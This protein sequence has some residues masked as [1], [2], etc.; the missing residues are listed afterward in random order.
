MAISNSPAHVS[1]QGGQGPI[2]EFQYPQG[3]PIVRVL[4]DSSIAW[5]NS[6][7]QDETY[8]KRQSAGVLRLTTTTRVATP[9]LEWFRPSAV[10]AIRVSHDSSS[11]LSIDGPVVLGQW[12]IGL[13]QRMGP[14]ARPDDRSVY[15]YAASKGEGGRIKLMARFPTG[16]DQAVAIEAE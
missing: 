10:Q 8:L 5:V 2:H 15:V 11:R 13:T 6:L 1:S 14:P 9:A 7:S 16:P 4:T 12:F 3:T